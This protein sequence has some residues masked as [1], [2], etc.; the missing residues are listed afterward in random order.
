V[1]RVDRVPRR[2]GAGGRYQ[3][4]ITAEQLQGLNADIRGYLASTLDVGGD[5][6]PPSWWWKSDVELPFRQGTTEEVVKFNREVVALAVALRVVAAAG[7]KPQPVAGETVLFSPVYRAALDL[8]YVTNYSAFKTLAQKT[9]ERVNLQLNLG[10][11]AGKPPRG[12][13]DDIRGRFD[14]ATS[15]ARRD[16]LT[17]VGA[18]YNNG[19]L[20]AAEIATAQTGLNTRVRHISALLFN[21]TRDAHAAR[22]NRL[23][24]IRE[25]RDWWDTGANRINCYC[26]VETVLT[27]AE[28]NELT[29]G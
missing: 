7:T 6:I 23:Y 2:R 28:G 17:Q 9:S 18:A 5:R 29:I 19:R 13:V 27:N 14:V 12:I 15:D 8:E 25:Q 3:Y 22:H 4:D 11:R 24:S 10:L 26:T 16:V 21:R 1:D 20:N